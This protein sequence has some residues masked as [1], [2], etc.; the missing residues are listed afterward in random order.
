MYISKHLVLQDIN[1]EIEK[2]WND[3]SHF[4]ECRYTPL[5][6]ELPQDKD[7]EVASNSVI[8]LG[9]N[10][11]FN[12]KDKSND[13]HLHSNYEPGKRVDCA[14]VKYDY[15]TDDI[16]Y[17]NAFRYVMRELRDK[18]GINK[19]WGHLDLTFFRET[20][21]KIAEKYYYNQDEAVNSFIWRQIAL[22]LK[23]L[24]QINPSI[25]VVTNAFACKVISNFTDIEATF[26]KNRCTY[27][28]FGKPLLKASM[29]SG[30]RA[31][32]VG[33]RERLI[34]HISQVLQE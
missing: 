13:F 7:G 16:P 14:P 6:F 2:I 11:S 28:L 22:S 8:F 30:G 15:D 5:T 10:P 25:V 33:S 17:F 18:Y 26:D 19:P 34:W 3:F 1:L 27:Q 24:K 32:D 23:I 21:Q 4:P 29:L 20:N 9:I 31:L 12:E